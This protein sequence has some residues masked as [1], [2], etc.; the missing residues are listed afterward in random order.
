MKRLSRLEEPER[1]TP[2]PTLVWLAVGCIIIGPALL[3]LGPDNG[4]L[5]L[6]GIAV[7]L[8]GGALLVAPQILRRGPTSSKDPT[9][10]WKKIL[11]D[12][13]GVGVLTCALAT[14]GLLS[15]AFQYGDAVV[16]RLAILVMWLGIGL[17]VPL[18]FVSPSRVT[19]T[20]RPPVNLSISD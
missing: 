20:V 18:V 12:I 14:A 4:L 17:V 19:A 1:N 2:K 13:L 5:L 3:A 10:P 6:P 8:F 7:L 11:R 16:V 9:S 15:Y